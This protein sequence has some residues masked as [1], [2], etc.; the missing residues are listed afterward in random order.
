[1]KLEAQIEGSGLEHSP[2]WNRLKEV[3]VGDKAFESAE[4]CVVQYIDRGDPDK[5]RLSFHMIR[6]DG[7]NTVG[8]RV[9]LRYFLEEPW[10][11]LIRRLSNLPDHPEAEMKCYFCEK[12]VGQVRHIIQGP[13]VN[14][15]EGRTDI[16]IKIFAEESVPH[17]S[18]SV[19]DRCSFCGKDETRDV[20]FARRERSDARICEECVK[21]IE[22]VLRKKKAK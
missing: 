14:I 19:V 8:F 1:M 12:T 2:R 22:E 3:I 15:C 21:L 7:R 4:K 13:S 11:H 17:W 20:K 10:E 9:P 16:S 6:H 5:S 18:I